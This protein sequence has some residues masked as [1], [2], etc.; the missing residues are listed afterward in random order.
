MT[1][2]PRSF[3]QVVEKSESV[4]EVSERNRL[5]VRHLPLVRTIAQKYT[6][7][8]PLE[9]LVQEG[10]I[11]LMKAIETFDPERGKFSVYAGWWIRSAITRAINR[12]SRTIR[13]PDHKAQTLHQLHEAT[14]EWLRYNARDPTTQELADSLGLEQAKV[15]ELLILRENPVSFETS[16][17]DSGEKSHT[18]HAILSDTNAENPELAAGLNLRRAKLFDWL[19]GAGL[20]PREKQVLLWYYEVEGQWEKTPVSLTMI[21][22]ELEV[23]KERVRQIRDSALKKAR[24]HVAAI[25]SPSKLA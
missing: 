14:D 25:T 18:F 4:S 20:D 13:L 16:I 3:E 24:R 8:M 1:A 2:G 7:F 23:T 6:R 22:K 21:G 17:D 12:S 10:S 5:V 9:D 19:D 15:E 11:G